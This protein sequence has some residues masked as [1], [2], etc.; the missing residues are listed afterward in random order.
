M[1]LV[2][3]IYLLG[4]FRTDHDYEEVKVGPGRIV[5]GLALPEPGPVP[6]P[7]PVRPAAARARS[8]TTRRWLVPADAADPRGP[9]GKAASHCEAADGRPITEQEKTKSTASPGG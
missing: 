7:R 6:G 9:E 5:G 2:C 1:A 3:G 8:G 4:L